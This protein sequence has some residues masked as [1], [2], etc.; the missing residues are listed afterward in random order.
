MTKITIITPSYRIDNLY[1]IKES[2]N[3]EYVHEWI[4]V[5]DGSKIITNPY[6]FKEDNKIKEYIYK[7]TGISGNGQRNYALSK[8]TN[9]NTLLYYLDD[10]NIIH[11][12]LY[13]LLNNID[14]NTIYSFN[15]YNRIKG[16]IIH[17]YEEEDN[18]G[19]I[20]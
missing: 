17:A 13:N 6:I 19:Y 3:F 11:P 20:Y 14:N 18:I 15:Q 5:Y 9:E 12:N 16:H 7:C 1:K 8:I 10:D 4:I 2:I